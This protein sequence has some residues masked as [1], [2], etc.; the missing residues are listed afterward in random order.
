MTKNVTTDNELSAL[1]KLANRIYATKS[2]RFNAQKRLLFTH[3]L[4]NWALMALAIYIIL[5]S[6]ANQF[7]I[8]SVIVKDAGFWSIILSIALLGIAT[9]ESMSERTKVAHQF[10]VNALDLNELYRKIEL[11]IE[12]NELD[13]EATY[14]E[15]YT[16]HLKACEHNHEKIDLLKFKYEN[17]HNCL[18]VRSKSFLSWLVRALLNSSFYW[19][20]IFAP[21]IILLIE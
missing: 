6:A 8:S 12:K 4:A 15:V 10:H 1:K 18:C 5:I 19:T 17:T 13:T 11:T 2:A 14:N 20:M 16:N 9:M 3:K 7:D 21:P